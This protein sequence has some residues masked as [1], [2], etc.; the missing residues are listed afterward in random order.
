MRDELPG[1]ETDGNEK[2]LLCRKENIAT[3]RLRGGAH[4]FPLL[5]DVESYLDSIL[6]QKGGCYGAA[7]GWRKEIALVSSCVIRCCCEEGLGIPVAFWFSARSEGPHS[8]ARETLLR[9]QSVTEIDL[10]LPWAED[11]QC[12]GARCAH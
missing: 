4:R 1:S 6:P 3:R 11:W 5:L 12:D 7:R 8:L 10:L 2:I 9:Q